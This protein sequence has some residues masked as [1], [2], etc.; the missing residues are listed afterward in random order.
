MHVGY[1]ASGKQC[2]DQTLYGIRSQKTS[3]KQGIGIA[4]SPSAHRQIERESEAQ[5]YRR[6]KPEGEGA[7]LLTRVALPPHFEACVVLWNLVQSFLVF[8]S[9]GFRGSGRPPSVLPRV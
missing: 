3:D 6:G 5:I 7:D 1:G 8:L 4:F 2:Q 9:N